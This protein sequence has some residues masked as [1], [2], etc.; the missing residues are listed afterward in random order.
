MQVENKTKNKLINDDLHF[1]YESFFLLQFIGQSPSLLQ[2]DEMTH[3]A[4]KILPTN[5]R[6]R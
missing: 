6:K 2:L 4:Y 3:S 1:K 5:S